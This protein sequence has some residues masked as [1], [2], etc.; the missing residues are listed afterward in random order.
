MTKQ[1]ELLLYLSW[2]V[3]IEFWEMLLELRWKV[4]N[5]LHIFRGEKYLCKSPLWQTCTPVQ[6]YLMESFLAV[7]PDLNLSFI[8]AARK[9][10][11]EILVCEIHKHF[12]AKAAIYRS[13]KNIRGDS[14]A[15]LMSLMSFIKQYLAEWNPCWDHLFALPLESWQK[16]PKALCTLQLWTSKICS[17]KFAAEFLE[18]KDKLNQ[19]GLINQWKK[20]LLSNSHVIVKHFETA[21]LPRSY[22][23]SLILNQLL[24]RLGK[25]YLL[26]QWEKVLMKSQYSPVEGTIVGVPWDHAG[27][28]FHAVP[29]TC[30]DTNTLSNASA[31][32][33]R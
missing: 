5:K 13:A 22:V 7:I 23:I 9:I 29:L 4:N 30:R 31:P 18:T 27:I 11:A 1:T 6:L 19:Q 3:R 28:F 17:N 32:S 21:C 26:S 14:C 12:P 2:Q 15:C 16:K 33:V 25:S 8:T 10:R 24:G 20:R